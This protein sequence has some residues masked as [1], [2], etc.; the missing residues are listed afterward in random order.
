MIELPRLTPSTSTV[1][2]SCGTIPRLASVA[3]RSTAAIDE[4]KSQVSSA[5]SR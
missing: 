4:W 3:K 1:A 2:S 5:A